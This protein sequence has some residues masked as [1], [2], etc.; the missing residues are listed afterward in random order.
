MRSVQLGEAVQY[1]EGGIT[2]KKLLSAM[3]SAAVGLS[4]LA[5]L[6]ATAMDTDIIGS[7][8]SEKVG[9][10]VT[11]K[12]GQNVSWRLE[13]SKLSIAG[14]GEMEDYSSSKLLGQQGRL[15]I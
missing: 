3:V 2:M 12:C 7:A 4:T 5:A 11:G 13:N 14:R 15:C 8:F 9:D 6:P 1:Q 10:A